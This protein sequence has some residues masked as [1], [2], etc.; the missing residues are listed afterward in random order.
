MTDAVV[1]QT[2]L[3]SMNKATPDMNVS[4]AHVE[5]MNRSSADATS[6]QFALEVMVTVAQKRSVYPFVQ[7]RRY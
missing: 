6:T 4:Q 3:E 2:T 7:V 1:S 5:V